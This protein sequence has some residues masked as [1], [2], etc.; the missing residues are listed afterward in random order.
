M[1]AR[2]V[3]ARGRSMV[4]LVLVIFVLVTSMI[5]WRR[6][7]GNAEARAMDALRSERAALEARK[8]ALERDV[9][10]LTSR[11][12][13][14]P[15]VERSLGLHVAQDSQQVFLRREGS[16]GALP[17]PPPHPLQQPES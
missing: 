12:V 10:D 14:A 4:A 8:A 9:R 11:A 2:R 16:S 15:I 1:A 17:T 13:L 7:V 6:S 5:I 3:R